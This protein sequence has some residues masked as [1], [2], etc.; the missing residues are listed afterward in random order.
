MQLVVFLVSGSF[1]PHNAYVRQGHYS[2]VL[3]YLWRTV[4]VIIFSHGFS[5]SVRLWGKRGLVASVQIQGIGHPISC[6]V[7]I[8]ISLVSVFFAC[9][10]VIEIKVN[11]QVKQ[12][13]APTL[14]LYLLIN[15]SHKNILKWLWLNNNQSLFSFYLFL[16]VL[17]AGRFSCFS[18][19]WRKLFVNILDIL[20]T[21]KLGNNWETMFCH[22]L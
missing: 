8:L 16:Y 15:V 18:I 4:F 11:M 9:V 6:H 10:M 17:P 12:S 7:S 3:S 19:W 20:L 2:L 1:C 5:Q 14:Y 13:S 22:I 21:E